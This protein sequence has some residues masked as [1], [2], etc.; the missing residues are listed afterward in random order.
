MKDNLIHVITGRAL[1]ENK[2][3]AD[4]KRRGVSVDVVKEL[5]DSELEE[6]KIRQ[7]RLFNLED[8][9]PSYLGALNGEFEPQWWWIPV[10]E[11]Y[12]KLAIT[13]ATILIGKGEIDQLIMGILIAM[14]AALVYFALQ[15]YKDFNDDLFSMYT[16]FQIFLVLLWSLLVEF[17]KLMKD[18][19]E[20]LGGTSNEEWDAPTTLL[21]T[22]TL[23]WLLILSNISVMFVF[24]V[25]MWIEMKNVRKTVKILERWDLLKDRA[26]ERDW[27][28][29]EILEHLGNNENRLSHTDRETV[30]RKFHK[31]KEKMRKKNFEGSEGEMKNMEFVMENPMVPMVGERP[32]GGKGGAKAGGIRNL[33]GADEVEIGGI[34][35]SVS[36]HEKYREREEGERER[37]VE[38]VEELEEIEC[39]EKMWEG[40]SWLIELK[41]KK[42]YNGEGEE[43]GVWDDETGPKLN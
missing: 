19:H 25:F 42:I 20:L 9:A 21:Q 1:Q 39:E 10:F 34:E 29:G 5:V 15:P 43:I 14:V 41:H 35:L 24:V 28:E 36:K 22:D 18:E 12:R 6:E 2:L 11:Q 4:V 23:G 38:E 30:L 31:R 37:G 7:M 26:V 8:S 16:H 32:F 33:S 3:A 13:G 40:R 17:Q 27:T